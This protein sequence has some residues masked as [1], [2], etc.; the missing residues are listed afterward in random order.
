LVAHPEIL[1]VLISPA[2]GVGTDINPVLPWFD[3]VFA[4]MA[5]NSSGSDGYLQLMNHARKSCLIYC[6]MEL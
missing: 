1:F 4:L 5:K 3:F 2:I 6:C